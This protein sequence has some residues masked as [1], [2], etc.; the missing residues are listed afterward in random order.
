MLEDVLVKDALDARVPEGQRTAQ[1]YDD[2]DSC[3]A[4]TVAVD[5]PGKALATAA[6]VHVFGISRGPLGRS[7]Q[8][9]SQRADEH[10]H[11]DSRP[12]VEPEPVQCFF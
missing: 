11:L 2:V 12:V 6:Q 8:I 10:R 9:R 3:P 5:E 1:V 7:S 4:H